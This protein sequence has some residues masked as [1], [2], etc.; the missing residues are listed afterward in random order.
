M[1]RSCCTSVVGAAV[2]IIALQ[3]I[4]SR[5]PSIFLE[6]F[7]FACIRHHQIVVIII[8]VIRLILF[9]VVAVFAA[10]VRVIRRSCRFF[11]SGGLHVHLLQ[12]VLE[13]HNQLWVVAHLY[14]RFYRRL[15]PHCLC[16]FSD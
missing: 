1:V 14:L 8:V 2:D 4:F 3:Q 13:L 10:I 11:C 5:Q 6:R 7:A 16:C 12:N 9:A 15:H